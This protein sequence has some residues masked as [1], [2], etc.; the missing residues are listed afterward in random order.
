MRF[1]SESMFKISGSGLIMPIN[2]VTKYLAAFVVGILLTAFIGIKF[3]YISL[4]IIF[5]SCIIA[6]VLSKFIKAKKLWSLFLAAAVGSACFCF[7]IFFVYKPAASFAS[8]TQRVTGT[9]TEVS[10]YTRDNMC[11]TVRVSRIGDK[12]FLIPFNLKIYTNYA[13]RCDYGDEISTDVLLSKITNESEGI[14]DSNIS[15]SNYLKGSLRSEDD[16]EIVKKFDFL[17]LFL[18][19]RDKL[20]NSVCM[21][22]NE[23]QS[24]I[25]NGL[26]LGRSDNI[27]YKI[28]RAVDRCGLSHI[29]CVSGLHISI[30]AAFIMYFLKLIKASRRLSVFVLANFLFCFAAM[31]GMTP[32]VIRACVMV[33]FANLFVLFHK[34]AGRLDGLF[35]AAALILIFSP[36][37]ILGLSFILSFSSCLGILLFAKS[38]KVWIRTKLSWYR[39]WQLNIIELFSVSLAANFASAPFLIFAFGK[40]SI[41]S[42]F[43]N[44]IIL[45][46]VPL[47]FILGIGVAISGFILTDLSNFL[48]YICEGLCGAVFY[49]IELISKIPFCYLPANYGFVFLTVIFLALFLLFTMVVKRGLLKKSFIVICSA[50][51][52]LIPTAN[53]VILASKVVTITA[54]GNGY[55]HSLVLSGEGQTVV[56][57]CGGG[58]SSGRRL[59]QFLDSRG[60]NNIDAFIFTSTKNKHMMDTLTVIENIS[61]SNLILPDKAKYSTIFNEASDRK[62]DTFLIDNLHIETDSLRIEAIDKH[63]STELLVNLGDVCFAYSDKIANLK[64]MENLQHINVAIIDEK[65]N[66]F[67]EE[68]HFDYSIILDKNDCS[69][70]N[71]YVAAPDIITNFIVDG[72]KVRKGRL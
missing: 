63:N 70:P 35:L 72:G 13:I 69:L 11:Y 42:P 61:V 7:H 60:I 44:L 31:V 67:D 14:F 55:G 22:I 59:C 65:L 30:L 20:A 40:I 10:D 64:A 71:S 56:I 45:P 53:T 38:I 48:G 54:I 39:G 24:H 21:A 33:L 37:A 58:A 49:V 26:V 68:I 29:F 3:C 19:Y 23:P 57:N 50:L 27:P 62:I 51:I 5:L 46:F 16:I 9:I 6:L 36:T 8:T 32:S 1:C 25:I 52:V 4:S 15:K 66:D 34:K 12:Q 28:K 43:V 47:L 17:S 18:K 2:C 41:I